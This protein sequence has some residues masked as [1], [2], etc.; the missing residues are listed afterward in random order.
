M[1]GTGALWEKSKKKTPKQKKREGLAKKNEA[2][3]RPKLIVRQ[4][5]KTRMGNAGRYSRSIET[6]GRERQ[7]G[8]RAEKRGKQ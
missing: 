7:R 8:S 1:R 2:K 4:K 6:I 5:K 3:L